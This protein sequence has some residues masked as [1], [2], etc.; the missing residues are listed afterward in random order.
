MRKLNDEMLC[1]FRLREGG[2]ELRFDFHRL[3]EGE[4]ICIWRR[5]GK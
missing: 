5:E 4:L 3:I 2:H 1:E